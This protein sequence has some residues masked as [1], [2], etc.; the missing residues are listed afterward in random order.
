MM[1]PF[2]ADCLYAPKHAVSGWAYAG[3]DAAWPELWNRPN[4]PLLHWP[5]GTH[6][7]ALALSDKEGDGR[8][9][10]TPATASGRRRRSGCSRSASWPRR[11]GLS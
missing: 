4:Y 8:A 7:V 5:D 6:D 9:C 11:A 3:H 1:R 10:R 2:A